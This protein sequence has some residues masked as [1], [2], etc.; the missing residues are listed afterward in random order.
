MSEGARAKFDGAETVTA[1]MWGLAPAGREGL[2]R[3]ESAAR[4]SPV[5]QRGDSLWISAQF[6]DR[7]EAAARLEI[8]PL[9][10]LQCD[11]LGHY[12]RLYSAERELTARARQWRG[13]GGT[14]TVLQM[15]RERERLGREL[16]TGVGQIL[17]AIR[18]QLEVIAAQPRERSAA[19]EQAL[20]RLWSLAGQ[21][22]DAV[23]SVSHR[24]HPPEWQR[25]SIEAA[26][27]QLWE[28]SGI[29]QRFEAALRV[30]PQAGEPPL[31][32]KVLIYRAAQE[33]LSNLVRHS[34]AT[35]VEMSLERA[36][37]WLVLTLEDNG[38]GFDS[39]GH[40]QAPASVASGIGLRS[41][42]EQAA[43][44]GGQLAIQSGPGGTKLEVSVP[45]R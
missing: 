12:F 5:F 44:L 22:L 21:A 26:L 30:E 23:R 35:S 28:V 19:V 7:A 31:E 41:I 34:R 37:G 42:R 6:A 8:S 39:R 2:L 24:L 3:V 15:E 14:Q 45:I 40:F 38:I 43:A 9:L 11:F 18:L 17:A 10:R 4:F 33:G 1:A 20:G 29:P 13:N 36:G 16:H 25:L 32:A 27:Q